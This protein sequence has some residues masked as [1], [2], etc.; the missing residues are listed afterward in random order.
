MAAFLAAALKLPAG[1]ERFTDDNGTP[2]EAAIN[3]VAAAG[4]TSG[5]DVAGTAFCP[6][7]T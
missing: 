2:F 4:I 3:A 5:C 1:P 6:I 7:K